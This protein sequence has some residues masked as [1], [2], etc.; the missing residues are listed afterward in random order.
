MSRYHLDELGSSKA[1]IIGPRMT[2][3]AARKRLADL[4][5]KEGVQS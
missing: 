2:E 1:T 3:K 5:S 4:R